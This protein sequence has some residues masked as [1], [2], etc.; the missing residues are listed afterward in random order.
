M[1]KII[2]DIQDIKSKYYKENEKGVF[3]KNKQKNELSKHIC[4]KYGLQQLLE[5]AISVKNS[6]IHINYVI[7]KS[8]INEDNGIVIVNYILEK[9][10]NVI[11]N[12]GNF[13]VSVNL[14]SFTMSAAQRYIEVIKLF[15]NECLNDQVEFTNKLKEFKIVNPPNI[16]ERLFQIFRNF[17]NAEVKSKIV[18]GK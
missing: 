11:F 15:C 14:E 18:L 4:T 1:E 16:M 17:V 6:T 9:F 12:H 5:A 8:F 3:N 13:S 2:N 10:R 7:L